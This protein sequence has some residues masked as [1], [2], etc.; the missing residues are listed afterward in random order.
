VTDTTFPRFERRSSTDASVGLG[1]RAMRRLLTTDR[2]TALFVIRIVLALVIFPHGAQK[3]F[4]WFGGY[5]FSGTLGYFTDTLGIPA[6]F[7]VLV[8]AAELVGGIGLAV[9]A[10]SRV[11]AAGLIAVM[12]GAIFITHLQHGFFMNWSGAQAGEGFEY[13]LLVIGMSLAT[14]IAGGGRW[15]VDR[16]LA[17]RV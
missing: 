7:A 3:V 9:G 4:G 6:L 10:L 1:S 8:F 16:R 17:A 5:G 15:S 11:A 14:L 2:S 13:H 12:T